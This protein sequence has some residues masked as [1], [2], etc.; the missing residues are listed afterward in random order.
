MFQQEKHPASNR[1]QTTECAKWPI[2][3]CQ[4]NI[5]ASGFIY[6]YLCFKIF[7]LH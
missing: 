7:E 6:F 3:P 1:I 4:E 5:I 2:V